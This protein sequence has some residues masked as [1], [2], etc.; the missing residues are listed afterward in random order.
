MQNETSKVECPVWIK[1]MKD[2]VKAEVTH[3]MEQVK[4]M[5]PLKKVLLGTGIV[6][7]IG[8]LVLINKGY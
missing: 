6:L 8:L 7:G 1:E 4:G 3:Q 2:E 5:S